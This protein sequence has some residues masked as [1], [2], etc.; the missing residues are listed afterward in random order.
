MSENVT[1]R[2]DYIIGQALYRFIQEQQDRPRDMQSGSDVQNAKDILLR[3]LSA[4]PF[5]NAAMRSAGR[6]QER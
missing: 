1:G 3:S 6:P 2:D 5:I 4:H